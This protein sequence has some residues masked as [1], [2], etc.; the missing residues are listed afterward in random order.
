MK[1]GIDAS[2]YIHA[3]AT[4]VEWYSYHLL[5]EL[6]PMLGR[7]HNSEVRLYSPRAFKTVPDLPFNVKKRI[8]PMK[9]F[10]TVLRLS[11]ELLTRPVDVLFVPSHTLPLVFPKKSVITIHDTAFVKLKGSY[12]KF[13][14]RL[15]MRTTRK[16]VKKAW[17]IIVPSLATRNDLVNL[18]N[19]LSDKIIV[20]PH[21]APEVPRLRIWQT[22]E[23]QQLLEQFRLKDKDLFIL[24]VGRL[25]AKKNLARLVEGFSRFLREFPEWKLVLAGKRGVGFERI[26][27]TV[28]SLGLRES[29]IMPGYVTEREKMFLLDKSRIFA[30]PS[31]Y[32]GFGLPVL[33]AFAQRRPVLTSKVSSLPEVAG[34]AAYLVD[35]E[36]TEEIGVGLKRLACDGV[37]VSKLIERGETQ[38][39]LF[40]WEKAARAT[41]DVIFGD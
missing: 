39:S 25:E 24:F 6:I 20:I 40:S 7:D 23:K 10:W 8:I 29:V 17:K 16:A 1:I 2:R 26:L 38:L 34:N 14:Y 36:K 30:F 3:E 18:F 41:F 31:L 19:C 37:L 21:G 27:E 5:N 33:E 12:D 22:H 4:G 15:L 13:Q 28:D 11:W 9:R 32:E 35:P